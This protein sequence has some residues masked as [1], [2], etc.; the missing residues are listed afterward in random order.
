[1][2]GRFLDGTV[3]ATAISLLGSL[4]PPVVVVELAPPDV[5]VDDR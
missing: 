1:M 3:D 4:R 2:A 5:P